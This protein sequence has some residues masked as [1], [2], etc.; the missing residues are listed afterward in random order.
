WGG[1]QLLPNLIGADAAVTVI[2]ENPLNQNRMLSAQQ[3]L[4]LGI[5]DVMVESADF[6][7]QSLVWAAK[8]LNGQ[9][10]VDRREVDRSEPTWAAA[11][12]RGRA[13][14]DGRVH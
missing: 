8:V 9:T 5:A 6:L 3:V 4:D 7:E 14:A 13:V 1:T 12:A 11:L 2:I 10:K